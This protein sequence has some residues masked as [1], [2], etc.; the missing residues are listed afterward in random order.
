MI[1]PLKKN[2]WQLFRLVSLCFILMLSG[3]SIPL[4]HRF[5]TD[6]S[7]FTIETIQLSSESKHVT[8]KEMQN[9]LAQYIG[10][11]LYSIDIDEVTKSAKQ[12]PWI[13]TIAIRRFPPHELHVDFRE[14]QPV[15]FISL[16]QIYLIDDEG[17]LFKLSKK[18][19]TLELPIITGIAQQGFLEK[20]QKEKYQIKSAIAAINEHIAAKSPGGK[21]S[22]LHVS[23]AF[24]ITVHFQS[25][26]EV[27][28]GK[29]DY[30]K[31]WLML[32]QILSILQEKKEDLDYAY[33]D[34]YPNSDQVAIR[35]KKIS[36]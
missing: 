3:I 24:R 15:A 29:D 13:K 26:L 12:H 16:Q 7:F 34:D 14:H 2:K 35:F 25:G 28:L 31:K 1:K 17:D 23:N 21:I 4:F 27:I 22:E 20:K 6:N 33:L 10:Q 32:L 30:K 11:S 18:T 9:Y 8:T 36:S 5:L 19:D